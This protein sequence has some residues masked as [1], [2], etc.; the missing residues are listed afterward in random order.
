MDRE[1][2]EKRGQNQKSVSSLAQAS[3]HLSII[4]PEMQPGTPGK[5][6]FYIVLQNFIAP[7]NLKLS[8]P[9]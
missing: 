7:H 2:S 8:M 3:G 5:R 4:Y 9:Q 1:I 6:D